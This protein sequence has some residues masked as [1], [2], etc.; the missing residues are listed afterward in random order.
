MMIKQSTFWPRLRS[1][2]AQRALWLAILGL[3]LTSL[4][5]LTWWLEL[6]SHFLPIYLLLAMAG[7]LLASSLRERIF[8]FVLV[9]VVGAVYG[10]ALYTPSPTGAYHP[11]TAIAFNLLIANTQYRNVEQWLN[12]QGAD[13][14]LLTEA[15]TEW[16]SQLSTLRQTLPHGC[17]AWEDNPFG[18][19]LLLKQA[20]RHCEVRFSPAMPQQYPHLRV[21]LADGLVVYG[22]HPPPPLGAELAAARDQQLRYLAQQIAQESAPVLVLGDFNITPFSPIYRA[23][24]SQAGLAELGFKLAPSWSPI[25]GWPL[26]PLD[27]ALARGISARLTIGPALGS[28]HRPIMVQIPAL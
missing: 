18:I 16:Q 12:A 6:F 7:L 17:A 5:G 9:T 23:F 2:L 27:R 15:T 26:L 13:V 24:R 25:I 14:I 1:Q 8:G 21:E 11:S 28:D 22:I 20:P 4:A 19:A 10:W 3:L